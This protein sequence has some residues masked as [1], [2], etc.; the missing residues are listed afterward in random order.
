MKERFRVSRQHYA[1]KAAP[2]IGRCL[3]LSPTAVQ[4]GS[5]LQWFVLILTN[6]FIGHGRATDWKMLA[7]FLRDELSDNCCDKACNTLRSTEFKAS[8]RAVLISYSS[9]TRAFLGATNCPQLP[10]NE[11]SPHRRGVIASRKSRSGLPQTVPTRG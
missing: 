8:I 10:A 11:A 1:C 3:H 4:F 2:P 7:A 5:W 6:I 9:T